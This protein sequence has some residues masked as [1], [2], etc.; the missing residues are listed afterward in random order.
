MNLVRENLKAGVSYWKGWKA[1]QYTH[2]LI[3]GSPKESFPLLPSYCH[4]L[5][6]KNPGTVTCIEVDG[7]KKFKFFFMALGVS[8]RGFACM[9]RVI[10]LDGTFL[11]SKCKGTLLVATCQD[12][13]YNSYPIAWGV[14][15]SERDESWSWFLTQLKDVIGEPDGLVF[16]S[17][18]HPSIQKGVVAIFLQATYGACY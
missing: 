18:R 6:L 3:R 4:M 9:R 14:I 10:S 8:I 15:D 11:K 13:N 16:I 12:S 17:D 2:F 7:N 5:K 1:R